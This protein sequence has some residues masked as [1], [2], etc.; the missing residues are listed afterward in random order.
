MKYTVVGDLWI[1]FDCAPVCFSL[2]A[3]HEHGT[4]AFFHSAL[5]QVNATATKYRAPLS[6][7]LAVSG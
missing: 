1:N 4:Q 6:K 3:C 7:C 5:Q 2:N